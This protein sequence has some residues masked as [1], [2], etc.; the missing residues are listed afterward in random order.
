MLLKRKNNWI[1]IISLSLVIASLLSMTAF[2]STPRSNS[3]IRGSSVSI[4]A[5][6]S[7]KVKFSV[8][9]TGTGVMTKIGCKSIV[10]FEST[11]NSNWTNVAAYYDSDYPDLMGANKVSYTATFYHQGVAGRYYKATVG[12]YAGN[13]SGG[14]VD[15]LQTDSV[16]AK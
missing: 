7:G 14:G 13:S 8:T 11:D 10:V 9:V 15:Y 12:V 6:G 2:A 5:A 3:F 16:K 4:S 1:R